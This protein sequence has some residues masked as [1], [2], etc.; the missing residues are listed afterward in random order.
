MKNLLIFLIVIILGSG[1]LTALFVGANYNSL[2]SLSEQVDQQY[3]VL[4][5]KL[6]R[7]YDLIPNLVNTVKGFLSHEEKVFSDIANARA[8]LTKAG[9]VQEKIAAD[10][11]LESALSRLLVVVENYPEL[12]SDKQMI[13]LMDELAGTENRISIERDNYNKVVMEYNKKVKTFPSNM[14]ASAFNFTE[15]TYFKADDNAST[16]PKVQMIMLLLLQ[17]LNFNNKLA[18][19][20]IYM[21]S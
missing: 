16:A 11:Q 10:N 21:Y 19:F 18:F 8:A 3:G 9:N 14:I 15:K 2:V 7:R 20:C 4:E 6:Q 13:A 1:V 12:K 5:S 17:K